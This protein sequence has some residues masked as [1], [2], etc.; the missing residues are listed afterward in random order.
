MAIIVD[1]VNA[2]DTR[3]LTMIFVS[4]AGGNSDHADDDRESVTVAATAS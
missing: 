1:T 3:R 2:I 4:C